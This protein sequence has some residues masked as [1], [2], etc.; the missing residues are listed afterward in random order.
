MKVTNAL[1]SPTNAHSFFVKSLSRHQAQARYEY[2]WVSKKNHV[3]E[4]GFIVANWR[5]I[6]TVKHSFL[7]EN[8]TEAAI[9]TLARFPEDLHQLYPFGEEAQ[10]HFV[11]E[12]ASKLFC[13][14]RSKLT[15]ASK[16]TQKVFSE[17]ELYTVILRYQFYLYGCKSFV[18]YKNSE[19]VHNFISDPS[20]LLFAYIK[21]PV[22]HIARF[23]FLS[24]T[25]GGALFF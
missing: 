4:S 19:F 9:K 22:R 6:C 14:Y 24:K 23:L 8:R 3:F 10:L 18:S 13:Y 12:Q 11:R 5:E 1:Q 25:H 21:E 2:L 7:G 15:K 16:R 20:F 17:D